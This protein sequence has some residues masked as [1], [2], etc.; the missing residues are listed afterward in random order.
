L[1]KKSAQK[2][3]QATATTA[4]RKPLFIE[5]QNPKTKRKITNL[6]K[7][8]MLNNMVFLFQICFI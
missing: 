2:Q 8:T 3:K 6:L 1:N 5:K 7:N 4:S